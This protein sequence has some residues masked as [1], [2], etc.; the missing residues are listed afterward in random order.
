ML[1][2]V[3]KCELRAAVFGLLANIFLPAGDLMLFIM[4]TLATGRFPNVRSDGSI[5]W[6]NIDL[7][8]QNELEL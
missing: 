5:H 8:V 6:L 7:R 1:L 2:A 3:D 4:G